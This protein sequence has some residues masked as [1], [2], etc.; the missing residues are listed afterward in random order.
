MLKNF[1]ELSPVAIDCLREI[2][3]IGSGNAASALS[4]MLSKSVRMHVPDIRILDYHAAINE[5]GGPEK[6]IT[7]ILVMF[8]GD[9]KGM[10]MFLLE[11]AFAKI[12]V[13]TFMG[14]DNVDVLKMDETDFSAVKE[15]GN[16]MAGS[17]LNALAALAGFTVSM[18]VPSMTVDMMGAIMNAPMT[19][20]SEVGDK[21]IYIDDGFVIDGVDINS[22]I[23]LI[24][25]MESLDILMKKLGVD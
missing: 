7:G 22:S 20:F 13:N 5:V 21:V 9:I 1:E 23:I 6:V 3:N 10:I 19:E 24:P 25:E 4:A 17:Y 15:M 14:K 16:I 11:D 2:G 18:D 12:V 8:S